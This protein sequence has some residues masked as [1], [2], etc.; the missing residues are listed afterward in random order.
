MHDHIGHNHIRHG[1]G[2]PGHALWPIWLNPLVSIDGVFVSDVARKRMEMNLKCR[3]QP[4]SPT[5]ECHLVDCTISGQILTCTVSLDSFSTVVC[6]LYFNIYRYL[7]RK[8]TW[9]ESGTF[10]QTMLLHTVGIIAQ[11]C[12]VYLSCYHSEQML[13]SVSCL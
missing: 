7:K 2:R 13:F 3:R 8:I 10:S 11:N 6:D 5:A 9:H 4:T 1:C 12:A